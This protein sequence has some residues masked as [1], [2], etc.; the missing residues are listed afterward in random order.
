[1]GGVR[2]SGRGGGGGGGGRVQGG[3]G[4]AGPVEEVSGAKHVEH[5]HTHTSENSFTHE[6]TCPKM[7][8]TTTTEERNTPN[9]MQE[10]IH[11]TWPKPRHQFWPNAIITYKKQVLA[12]CGLAK[13][14]YNSCALS[15]TST[16]HF[17]SC[18]RRQTRGV[19]LPVLRRADA[20]MI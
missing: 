5:T 11:Q 14:G 7:S 20:A 6:E 4:G 16:S 19:D 18:I 13:C 12:K 3:A 10:H 9:K 8:L 15:E 2:G 1:M 17:L